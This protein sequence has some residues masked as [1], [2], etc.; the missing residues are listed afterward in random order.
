MDS[1]VRASG[2]FGKQKRE[3]AIRVFRG[4]LGK[5]D[6]VMNFGSGFFVYPRTRT[7]NPT[8]LYFG[9]YSSPHS[10]RRP[11]VAFTFRPKTSGYRICTQK[12]HAFN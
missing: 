5:E 8:A 11:G 1:D 3:F 7:A 10:R 4:F 9:H 6:E 12:T 2:F